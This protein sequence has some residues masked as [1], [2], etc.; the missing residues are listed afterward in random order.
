MSNS[1][2]S[3][4]VRNAQTALVNMQAQRGYV[5]LLEWAQYQQALRQAADANQAHRQWLAAHGL[6]DVNPSEIFAA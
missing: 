1:N 5:T 4:S 6:V 2:S 3:M